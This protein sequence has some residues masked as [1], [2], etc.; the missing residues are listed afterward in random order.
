MIFRII[1]STLFVI[2]LVAC[3]FGQKD[4]NPENWCR[5]GAFPSD[6]ED[7]S[8][9]V[10]SGKPGQKVHFY[11]DF[12]ENCPVNESCRE[13]SYVV[14]GDKLIVSRT[15][16]NYVCSWYTPAKGEPTTGWIEAEN[17]KLTPANSKPL[18]SAWLGNWRY[19][20][21]NIALTGGKSGGKVTVKGNAFWKGQG[22]NIHIGEVD[23]KAVPKGNFLKLGDNATDEF[24]C[25]VTMILVDK[26]LVV[27]DNN[28]CGGANVTFTGVYRRGK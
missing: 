15:Y 25:K 2:A 14:P 27:S 28:N 13:K 23:D 10:V 18:A 21:N 8:V 9:G 4:G 5:N 22:D 17:V 24:A 19:F 12:E 3:A 16:K 7:F 1:F 11:N 20:D 6:T 26:F